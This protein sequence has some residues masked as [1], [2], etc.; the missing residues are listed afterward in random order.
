MNVNRNVYSRISQMQI[1]ETISKVFKLIPITI[2]N[3]FIDIL[4]FENICISL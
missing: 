3:Y 2:E 1:L 4:D